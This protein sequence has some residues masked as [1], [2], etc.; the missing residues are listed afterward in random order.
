MDLI[1]LDQDR[2]LWMAAVNTVVNHEM[3]AGKFL[4]SC[5]TGGLSSTQSVHQELFQM[6]MSHRTKGE[7]D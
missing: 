3:N 1:D 7:H 6:H 2:V 5:T 4:S